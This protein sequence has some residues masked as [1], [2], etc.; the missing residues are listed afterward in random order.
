MKAIANC[1][2]SPRI[3]TVSGSCFHRDRLDLPSSG[4]EVELTAKWTIPDPFGAHE[5]ALPIEGSSTTME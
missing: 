1:E 5:F 2:A 4:F 3:N